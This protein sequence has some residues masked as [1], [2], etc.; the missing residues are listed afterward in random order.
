MVCVS[1]RGRPLFCTRITTCLCSQICYH[2]LHS[3]GSAWRLDT[4][5]S[6]G[7]FFV[8]MVLSLLRADQSMRLYH[9]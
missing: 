3:F 4:L 6:V 5:F 9:K 1:S 8:W 2:Q 7:V